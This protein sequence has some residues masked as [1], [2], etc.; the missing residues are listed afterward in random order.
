MPGI[1]AGAARARGVDH[2]PVRPQVHHDG[3]VEV[4]AVHAGADIAQ[5]RQ[6]RGR[7]VPVVVAGADGD[8]GELGTR[9]V[10]EGGAGRRGAPVV[11]HLEDVDPREAPGDQPR[12]HVVLRV[13][14]EQEAAAVRLTEQDDRRVVDAAAGGRRLNGH[15]GRGPENRQRH[16]VQAQPG[17]RRERRA[18]RAVAVAQRL[19]PGLPARALAVHPGLE[20]PAHPVPLQDPDEAG[21][22]V[23]VGMRQHDE[24]DPAIPRRDAGIELQEQP[25]RVRS[26][27]H[28][29]P[30]AGPALDEDRVALPD[31]EHHEAGLPAGGVGEGDGRER[32]D[33]RRYDG[34]HAR[35]TRRR[36]SRRLRRVRPFTVRGAARLAMAS[37]NRV[38]LFRRDP[39]RRTSEGV[40]RTRTAV[41]SAAAGP[42]SG[43]IAMAAN[44]RPAA[45]RTTVDD[46]VQEQP[47]RQPEDRR[48]GSREAEHRQGAAGHR[49]DPGGHRRGDQRDDARG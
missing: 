11:G 15:P 19:A 20:D 5:T 42:A 4:R 10:E 44:G 40:A 33:D 23:L 38:R 28:E 37:P 34:Q 18:R 47:G 30:A 16:L 22:V 48:H 7:R 29:H 41:T 9:R 24:V 14:G 8:E 46:D 49:Q 27:V 1:V 6:G 21:D 25:L 12:V 13:A 2:Q 32:D 45:I 3:P 17:T 31:V 35:A 26:A 39:T 36:V 43:G